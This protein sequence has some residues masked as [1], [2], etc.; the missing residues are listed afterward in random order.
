M[1][2]TLMLCLALA[3]CGAFVAGCGGRRP[4]PANRETEHRDPS[5]RVELLGSRKVD[6]RGEK[7]TIMVTAAEGTFEA[8]RLEVEGNGLEMWDV[9]ITYGDGNKHSP[10]TRL[11]FGEDSWSRRIDLPGGNR[12]IRKVEFKYK[13]QG[14][15][16]EGRATIK[17][18]GVH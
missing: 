7:D 3:L 11:H 6:F 8:I 13:S 16:R 10:A 18:F 2:R 12:V 9:E 15:R 14:P 4:G 17:L 5:D 1:Q